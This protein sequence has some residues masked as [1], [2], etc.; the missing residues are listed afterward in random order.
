MRRLA[1]ANA[2]VAMLRAPGMPA[3]GADLDH[4]T[5]H[6]VAASFG[7]DDGAR[8]CCPGHQRKNRD[9]KL[10]HGAFLRR[11]TASETKARG[12]PGQPRQD[13]YRRDNR[14]SG[15]RLIVTG[16]HLSA[17]TRARRVCAGGTMV[18]DMISGPVSETRFSR[19]RRRLAP[20]MPTGRQPCTERFAAPS[21]SSPHP[22]AAHPRH[23][24]RAARTILLYVARPT[25]SRALRS[26]RDI[27]CRK[28]TDRAN[29]IGG[30]DSI[31]ARGCGCVAAP[32]FA[33]TGRSRCLRPAAGGT[34]SAAPGEAENNRAPSAAIAANVTIPRMA[35]KL[36]H[37]SRC[38]NLPGLRSPFC[39]R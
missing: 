12:H 11:Q 4:C 10:E 6:A 8:N 34:V 28:A 36:P 5:A 9:A 33:T 30:T 38:V 32:G 17:V 23:H 31:S 35:G 39:N 1:G 27:R 37:R 7:G 20:R 2:A 19:R 26:V 16:A 25:Q 24:H 14:L 13:L 21:R 3:R 18:P 29:G 22:P 15:R